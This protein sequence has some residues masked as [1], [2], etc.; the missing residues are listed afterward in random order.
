MARPLGIFLISGGKDS[1]AAALM[2]KNR[3]SR[4]IGV[5]VT[6][7]GVTYEDEAYNNYLEELL[8]LK[9]HLL[10]IPSGGL[11]AFLSSRGEGEEICPVPNPAYRG[12]PIAL[13]AIARA[14]EDNYSLIRGLSKS[15][16]LGRQGPIKRKRQLYPLAEMA[17]EEISE[18]LKLNGV[19]LHPCY[20]MGFTKHSHYPSLVWARNNLSQNMAAFKENFSERFEYWAEWEEKNGVP[21]F[22]LEDGTFAKI[23]DF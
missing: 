19:E 21:F 7:K 1:V 17:D 15:D 2:A 14:G 3:F 20:S 18:Y 23:G 4:R 13:K 22:K 16:I 6:V 8:E 11:E 10:S 9:I 12:E 5:M